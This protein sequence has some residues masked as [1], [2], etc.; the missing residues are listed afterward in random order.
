M[1]GQSRRDE[2]LV[3][4]EISVRQSPNEAV[5]LVFDKFTYRADK[6]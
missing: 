4:D 6:L 5:S 1:T 3:E 2:I